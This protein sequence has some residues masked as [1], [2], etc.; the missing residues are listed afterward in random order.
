MSDSA[1]AHAVA[2]DDMVSNRDSIAD[3]DVIPDRAGR[4]DS[5]LGK[6]VREHADR[7]SVPMDRDSTRLGRCAM[8]PLFREVG[9]DR[10]NVVGASL[11]IFEGPPEVLAEQ[12]QTQRVEPAEEHDDDDRGGVA[13]DR[14]GAAQTG[15]E[16]GDPEDHRCQN[17]DEAGDA[18]QSN[19]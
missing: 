14:Y 8:W 11:G 19:R 1:Q 7:V 9:R 12:P 18:E 4:A 6:D 15:A 3:R 5:G 16:H 17:A 10:D 2:D 13:G